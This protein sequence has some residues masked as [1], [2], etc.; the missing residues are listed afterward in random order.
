MLEA[1]AHDSRHTSLAWHHQR[2]DHHGVKLLFHAGLHV[3]NLDAI[4]ANVASW[5]D[6]IAPHAATE[7]QYLDRLLTFLAWSFRPARCIH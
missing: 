2:D 4:R 3:H 1:L 5:L 6:D 7:E